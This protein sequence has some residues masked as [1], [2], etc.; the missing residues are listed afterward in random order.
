MAHKTKPVFW[1]AVVVVVAGLIGLALYRAKGLVG[2]V[3][4]EQAAVEP[5]R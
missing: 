3:K 2:V 4:N 1:F 5:W